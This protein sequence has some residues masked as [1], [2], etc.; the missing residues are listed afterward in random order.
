MWCA[1][2]HSKYFQKNMNK[3][4]INVD[5]KNAEAKVKANIVLI[6]FKEQDN[7]IVYSPH[8]EVTGYGKS[9]DEA[10]QSFNHC[11][12]VFLDY[13]VNKKTLHK[14]L[15]SLG[16]QLKKGSTKNPKK[17][18]AP[19]MSDLLKHNTTLKELLNKQN[20]TTM[21]KEVAIPV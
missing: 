2:V 3:N 5:F 4:H 1:I 20:I 7:Y 18:N 16:W 9:E 13:T 19:S 11:L 21:Q 17:I 14:E 12:A 6:S 10:M 15:I 8:L